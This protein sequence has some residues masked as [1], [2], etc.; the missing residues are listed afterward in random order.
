MSIPTLFFFVFL[1]LKLTHVIAWS[2]W[3]VTAPLWVFALYSVA[4]FGA[5]LTFAT[6]RALIL[7][8]KSKNTH[9]K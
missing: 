9:K 3:W 8:N 5:A 6:I 1:I 7:G 4:Y 2:W